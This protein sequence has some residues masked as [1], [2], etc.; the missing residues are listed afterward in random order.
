MKIS[1]HDD[2]A[3]RLAA[4][5]SDIDEFPASIQRAYGDYKYCRDVIDGGP[6]NPWEVAIVCYL[7]GIRRP[8]DEPDPA[9]AEPTTLDLIASGELKDG[10]VVLVKFKGSEMEG[11]FRGSAKV[12]GNVLV[13]LPDFPELKEIRP[14]S[15]LKV[16][17][18]A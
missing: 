15:I 13:D 7:S 12:R 4:R 10:D 5:L 16:L 14:A 3:L 9:D 1:E 18:P 11:I 6:L 17:Q 8:A 2:G